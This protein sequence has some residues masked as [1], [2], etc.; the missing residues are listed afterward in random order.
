MIIDGA[1]APSAQSGTAAANSQ[2]QSFQS[3]L[4]VNSNIAGMSIISSSVY[5]AGGTI[6]Y[7]SSSNIGIILGI[8][9]PIGVISIFF[10]I[11]IYF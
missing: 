10:I 7:E 6:N 11:N 8:C 3:A 9:I 4:S 1:F 5:V 2:F